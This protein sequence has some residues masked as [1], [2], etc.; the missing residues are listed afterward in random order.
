L[1]AVGG[2]EQQGEPVP[3]GRQEEGDKVQPGAPVDEEEVGVADGLHPH[4]ILPCNHLSFIIEH[5][6]KGHIENSLKGH[7][8]HSLR[9]TLPNNSPHIL[10][11]CENKMS[12]DMI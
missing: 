1:Y 7:I 3:T 6:L 4:V 8:E 5:S 2:A 12:Q 11:V 10:F 9:A